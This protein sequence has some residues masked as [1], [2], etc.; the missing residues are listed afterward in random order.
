[1]AEERRGRQ[2]QE[3]W[4]AAPPDN[5]LKAAIG[6][7]SERTWQQVRRVVGRLPPLI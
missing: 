4:A 3:R 2:V 6:A 7:L 1:M 5:E